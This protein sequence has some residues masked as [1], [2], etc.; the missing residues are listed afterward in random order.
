MDYAIN[1]DKHTATHKKT[2]A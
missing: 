2:I 1:Q